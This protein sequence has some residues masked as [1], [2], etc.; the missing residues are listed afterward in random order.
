MTKKQ[1]VA[2]FKIKNYW[3]TRLPQTWYSRKEPGSREWFN[4]LEL[5]RYN[6]Y[7]P[8]IKEFAG[9]EHHGGERVLEV[10]VGVGTELVQYAKYGAIV[11]GID[12]TDEAIRMAKRNFKVRSL[13]YE[14]LQTADAENL[15]FNDDSFDLVTSWGVLHHTPNTDQA[16]REIHRVLKPNGNAIVF[17]Y[18]R[19]WKHYFKRIGIHGILLGGLLKKGYNK[20][21]NDQ[22]EVHGGSPLT[23]VFT[24]R[25]IQ[26]MFDMFGEVDIQRRNLGEYIDYAPYGTKKVP[27]VIKNTLL[28]FGLDRVIGES[29]FIKAEKGEPIERPSFWS[30]LLKP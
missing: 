10:G 16:I 5:K 6:V 7:Y 15:P 13:E 20:L 26:N 25:E 3:E 23:Y 1:E 29:Y 27:A 19:G 17:I 14:S 11:S 2:K 12:L 21:V 22:T 30:T 4:E 18:A 8:S 9:F 28:L 24:R